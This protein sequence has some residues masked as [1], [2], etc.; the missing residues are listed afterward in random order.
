[1]RILVVGAGATGG[2]FGARLAQAGRDVTFLVRERRF[3]QLQQ[4]G[5]VLKTPDGTEVLQPQLAQ[6]DSLNSHYDLI[7]LTVKSFA[8][9]QAMND[10]APAVGPDTLIMPIL[11]GMRHIDTLRARFG[12]KVIGGLCKINA[13]LGENGEV[14]QMTPLHMLYYGALD[15]NN[16]ARLQRID[17]T[18]RAAQ[19]DTL[20]SDNIISELWEKW[21]L[22]S[23]LGA[24]CC[25]A[26][27]NTQQVLNA[28][29]GEALLQTIFG[30]VLAVLS[31]EGYQQR[32]AVTAKI[33][34]TLNNPK[35]AMTSSMYRDLAQGYEIEADQVIGDLLVRGA[36]SGVV[37][38]LL[39]AVY[40][41]LQVYVQGR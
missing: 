6:A 2:Y 31:A 4:T 14:V 17:E 41:N 15:G 35:A 19:F 34:E 33:Y 9:E 24:V 23:T 32:P 7:I 3:Q 36:R 29:G 26:R 40:V 11:N 38:P 39:N 1:M 27:G 13:T 18:L 12:D 25:I 5:L 37:T 30:E 21:L 28:Q 10:I 22:L 16:D 20:F 8:L